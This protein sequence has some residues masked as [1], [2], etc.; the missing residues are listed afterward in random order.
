MVPVGLGVEGVELDRVVGADPLVVGVGDHRQVVDPGGRRR[1]W[2][3][4]LRSGLGVRVPGDVVRQR[5]SVASVLVADLDVFQVERGEHHF[6]L[7]TG[8]RGLDLVGVA[9]Q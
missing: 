5:R 3:R 6:D 7:P 4:C 8:Q 1:R 2:F 9:V